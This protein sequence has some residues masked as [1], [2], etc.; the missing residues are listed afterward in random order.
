MCADGALSVLAPLLD[1]DG[2][3][4]ATGVL[5]DMRIHVNMRANCIAA[6]AY[7]SKFNAT[8]EQVSA[9]EL[10]A[11]RLSLPDGAR[12][13]SDAV[14]SIL[15]AIDYAN[16]AARMQFISNIVLHVGATFR[17][18][19]E[20]LGLDVWSFKQYAPLWQA[21]ERHEC[22]LFD[23]KHSQKSFTKSEVPR[24]AAPGCFGCLEGEDLW[25]FCRGNCAWIDKPWY[26][27][28]TCRAEVRFILR[29]DRAWTNHSRFNTRNGRATG[30]SVSHLGQ[31]RLSS[32][33]LP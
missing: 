18:L 32:C 16:Q 14:E 11:Q 1:L 19:T 23:D 7:L 5:S 29:G 8:P 15:H 28:S 21:V 2:M 33:R 3:H 9:A 26:C 22:K 27:S 13:A 30:R 12:R 25:E 31:A 17:D 6:Y 24:C 20:H 10:D 4:P